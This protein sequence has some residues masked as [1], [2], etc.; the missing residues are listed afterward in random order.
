MEKELLDAIKAAAKKGRMSVSRWVV[1]ASIA[2]LE[3]ERAAPKKRAKTR[4]AK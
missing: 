4:P 3:Q 1:E 2:Q